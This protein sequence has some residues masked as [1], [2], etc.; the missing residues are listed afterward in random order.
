LEKETAKLKKLGKS[1]A[2][3]S[4][5]LSGLHNMELKT[6]AKIEN[7]LDEEV[8]AVTSREKTFAAAPYSVPLP[9]LT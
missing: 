6:I 3:I 8:L 7:A 1:E 2:E 9:Y 5:W 4:K